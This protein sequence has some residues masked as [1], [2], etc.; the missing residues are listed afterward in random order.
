MKSEV[1]TYYL[2]GGILMTVV[3]IEAGKVHLQ[4]AHGGLVWEWSPAEWAEAAA[5]GEIMVWTEGKE[6][7]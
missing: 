3:K 5:A 1:G 6:I 4:N 7:R 2:I